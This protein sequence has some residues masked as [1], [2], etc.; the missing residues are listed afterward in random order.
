MKDV[1]PVVPDSLTMDEDVSTAEL[2]EAARSVIDSTYIVDVEVTEDTTASEESSEYMITKDR[3]VRVLRFNRDSISYKVDEVRYNTDQD[4]YMWYLRD[5][6]VLPDIRL[7]QHQGAADDE[8]ATATKE[9][10]G[11][12]GFFKN[13]F[14]KKEKKDDIPADSTEMEPAV[15]R[16]EYDLDY[17]EGEEPVVEEPTEV[18]KEKK[19]LFRKK[20]KD[21]GKVSSGSQPAGK[22]KK[23]K[24]PK[25]EPKKSEMREDEKPPD[26]EA[27]G[28]EGF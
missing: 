3:E 19:G 22:A 1:Q 20:T 11:I 5:A 17:V 4:N 10:K 18:K 21:E 13:L 6:I 8:E 15:E 16:S 7:A 24:K 23:E 26:E 2:D 9:K 12:A 14:K 28:D 25:K 27:E